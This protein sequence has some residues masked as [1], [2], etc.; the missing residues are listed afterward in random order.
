MKK[1]DIK[2]LKINKKNISINEAYEMNLSDTLR[3]I[4]VAGNVF[5]NSVKRA[6]EIGP[7]YMFKLVKA[8]IT[9]KSLRAVNKEVMQKQRNLSTI[10]KNLIKSMKGASDLD[11]ML[12]II[13][14]AGAAISKGL[15]YAPEV[16]EKIESLSDDGRNFWNET[17]RQST[18]VL[19]GNY[20]SKSNPF[21]L[22]V[23]QDTS[24]ELYGEISFINS[25]VRLCFIF[26]GVSIPQ[27]KKSEDKKDKSVISR[28]FS[29]INSV[30]KK[31][32]FQKRLF[33]FLTVEDLK[34][35]NDKNIK[36][37][38]TILETE[39]RPDGFT[40]IDFE[41]DMYKLFQ[42]YESNG[43]ISIAEDTITK[44]VNIFKSK[45]QKIENKKLIFKKDKLLLEASQN[46]SLLEV[47]EVWE[48]IID[49]STNEAN[50]FYSVIQMKIFYI[51]V[52]SMLVSPLCNFKLYEVI[53]NAIDK[54]EKLDNSSFSEIEK[55]ISDK[56]V[57]KIKED[58]IKYINEFNDSH[59]FID[60]SSLINKESLITDVN[61]IKLEECFNEAS[62]AFQK[63]KETSNKENTFVAAKNYSENNK[64]V[65]YLEIE[66]LIQEISKEIDLNKIKSYFIQI[67]NNK[68][69]SENSNNYNLLSKN[70]ENRC[71]DELE[72]IINAFED[73]KAKNLD[74]LCKE[75]EE[76]LKT[77]EENL[78]ENNNPDNIKQ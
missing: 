5:I 8:V 43:E 67:E 49:K 55:F 46:K 4:S 47:A 76:K 2:I 51:T 35:F 65:N 23:G 34:N 58:L 20:P 1:N 69:F 53:N 45:G 52:K 31:T 22:D 72:K 15:E 73:L 37:L 36:F 50:A 12:T 60:N 16:S 13:N 62:Q 59:F 38:Y 18:Y 6:Y 39:R 9:G 63:I 40:S 61:N 29:Q 64:D 30:V 26:G 54:E 41:K 11:G 57:F 19:T 3:D 56:E 14:P 68:S 32:I 77:I 24:E 78:E 33:D 10:N 44:V 7:V 42:T 75:L 74:I 66:K 70:I 27:I 25:F 48:S 71:F 21:L 17:F 28:S